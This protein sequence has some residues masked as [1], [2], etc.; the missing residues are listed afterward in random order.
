MQMPLLGAELLEC[1]F[2]MGSGYTASHVSEH[3]IVS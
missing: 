3:E 2:G 1:Y